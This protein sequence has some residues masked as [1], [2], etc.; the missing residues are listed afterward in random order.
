MRYLSYI[1][2]IIFF[3]G[4]ASNKANRK[5]KRANRLI[6]EAE[7]LGVKWHSDTVKT[8][9]KFEGAKAS[10]NWN[11]VLNRKESTRDRPVF[12]DT[13]IFIN[14]IKVQT[15]DSL[16][17]IECPEVEGEVATAINKEIKTGLGV[18]TVV[19]WSVLALLV[20]AVLARI[21]WK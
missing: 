10:L 20:G 17:Y 19:Q 8:K 2:L 15:K 21:F 9:F 7:Q 14:K 6:G 13:T 1:L 11:V 3:T 5:L 18:L 16:V 4:C 12:K